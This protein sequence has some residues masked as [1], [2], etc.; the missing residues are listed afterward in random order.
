MALNTYISNRPEILAEKLAENI[1]R[2]LSSPLLPETCITQ[3]AGTEHW[4]KT[5]F[6]E[7]HGI[8]ANIRFCYPNAFIYFLLKQADPKLPERPP[9]EPDILTWKIMGQIPALIN[10]DEFAPLKSYLSDGSEL[11]IFQISKRIAN[12]FDQYVIFRPDL[13]KIWEKGP[14]TGNIDH[15]PW[16]ALL[17]QRLVRDN[18]PVHRAH[19]SE[20][21]YH[22]LEKDPETAKVL[23]ERISIFGITVLPPFHLD[24]FSRLANHTDIS[25]FL[26]NPCREYWGD[27]LSRKEE[28]KLLK[29]GLPSSRAHMTRGHP[30][31]SSLGKPAREFF[32]LLT[33]TE[34]REELLFQDITENS[35]LTM[36]QSGILN[37]K[38]AEETA[39]ISADD[40]SIRIHSC[41]S[42][43][44][45]I[46]VLHDQLL[47]LFA[48]NAD[49]S[50]HDILVMT[51]DINGYTPFIRAVFDA[52]K[53]ENRKIPFSISDAS[54][55]G[56]SSL[57]KTFLLLLDI[58]RGRF[59]I[60]E[61]L[62]ILE[63]P[64]VRNKFS[65]SENDISLIK[66]W[67]RETQV[68]WGIDA[69]NRA[70]LD[71]PPDRQNTWQA[72]LDRLLL[73]YAMP[74]EGWKLF[75]D[76]LPFDDIEGTAAQSLG[77][78]IRFTQ[79]LFSLSETF[80]VAKTLQQWSET[81]QN[82]L[83]TFFK[84]EEDDCQRMRFLT[85]ALSELEKLQL[86]SGLNRPVSPA[87]IKAHLVRG[88]QQ[89][90]SSA[91]FMTGSVTFC[92]LES[93]RS[94]PAR[95]VC[96]IGM[97]DG[98]FPRIS[99]DPGFN[100]ISATP[101]AC[102]PSSKL[103]DRNLFLETL[104]CASEKLYISYIGQHIRDN[105]TIP[106]SVIVSELMD[107][108]T[109][110]F[111]LAD[112]PLIEQLVV[113]HPL[114]AFSPDY[115]TEGSGLF[116]YS[117]E[118]R[119]C[120]E[121]LVNTKTAPEVPA[122]FQS[123]LPLPPEGTFESVDISDLTNFFI[124]PAKFLLQHRLNLFLDI[125]EETFEDR[126]NFSLNGL[127]RY[128]VDQTLLTGLSSGLDRE[129]LFH[130]A[131]AEG[132]LPHGTLGSSCYETAFNRVHDFQT[133]LERLTKNRPAR[134][135]TVDIP[136]G[137]FRLQGNVPGFYA[138]RLIRYRCARFKSKDLISLWIAH[139]VLC[140]ADSPVKEDSVLAGIDKAFT[141]ILLSITEDSDDI[142][143]N[144]LQMYNLGLTRPLPLF[145]EASLA[146]AQSIFDG[147]DQKKA[148]T[149]AENKLMG[150]KH[151]K[152]DL[153]D[154]YLKRCFKDERC[155]DKNFTRTADAFYQPLL[156]NRKDCR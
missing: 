155:L 124:N 123:P 45:E 132:R 30:L 23:P 41:H 87:V 119:K 19:L 107:C 61:V 40:D 152:G 133:S 62:P 100:L 33:E 101:R 84:P 108:L 7:N 47:A 68:R 121:T 79:A 63:T 15:E 2:P 76:I 74:G 24:F 88:L 35:M 104:V 58:G 153:S 106:P 90:N 64:A 82:I 80:A 75:N 118:N 120:A 94:I 39:V 134:T 103:E 67:L 147:K 135:L 114:H 98:A 156:K 140:S 95:V 26:L 81:L 21:F 109:E 110:T 151:H 92:A 149:A 93:S 9:F 57:V 70:G 144:L 72:G 22:A 32:D 53:D 77:Q 6:S 150:N 56:E 131:R 5:K 10:R 49:L 96:L 17:W 38:E 59:N 20:K 116:S 86:L 128:Q 112:K 55:L 46:E 138:N 136:L 78:L 126:E 12:I 54:L 65:F 91:G 71:L 11:K 143:Q 36:L 105:T 51:P 42:P 18:G 37:L 142:L 125:R 154:P 85:E 14:C 141:T 27:I 115:F 43:M 25:L 69:N 99:C 130:L 31:L 28:T 52:S 89:K 145:P 13:L 16:Q 66:S 29:K 111:C 102:D 4:L 122:F 146:Y 3:H 73:G 8:C 1:A 129:D 34:C 117:E 148:L 137:R 50:P 48:K 44:R 97:N 139:L 113:K 60:T 83:N 127:D